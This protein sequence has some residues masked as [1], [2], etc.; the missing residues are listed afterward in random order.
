MSTSNMI[1][2]KKRDRSVQGQTHTADKREASGRDL[3]AHDE[4]ACVSHKGQWTVDGVKGTT[5]LTF[6]KRHTIFSQGE[7]ADAVFYIQ[8][9][10]V[11]L[12][13]VGPQALS[14]NRIVNAPAATIRPLLLGFIGCI[15]GVPFREIG[16]PQGITRSEA[17]RSH[18]AAGTPM[19]LA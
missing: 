14:S 1:R 10:R 7:A 8:A 6:P 11:K 3:P 18:C 13:V 16:P 12:T 17:R 15:L 5:V 19:S 4:S 2:W 9:G